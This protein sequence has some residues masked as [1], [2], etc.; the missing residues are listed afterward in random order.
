MAYQDYR[1]TLMPIRGDPLPPRTTVGDRLRGLIPYAPV[2][3]SVVGAI[4]SAREARKNRE[5][6][7]RMSNTAHQR[8]VADLRSAGLNPVLS[9]HGGASSPAGSMGDM[10]G[11]GEAIP[12]GIA[13]AL[14]IRQAEAQIGLTDAQ[15]LQARTQ[16]YDLQTS[17]GSRYGLID[18]QR[19]VAE[20]NAAQ[21]RE[22]LPL[23]V[24][25]ARA[26]IMRTISG[27]RAAQAVAAL[28]EAALSGAMNQA[29][30]E[31]LIGEAGPALRLLFEAL[32]TIRRPR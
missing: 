7:E 20:G 5:F 26:E 18:A 17:A 25:Q 30:F 2:I 15:A 14:G 8:E 32:R 9:G 29:E 4:A 6:Q 16:A 23:M 10:S 24:E 12:K 28:D 22:M 31:K 1:Q 13:A 19:A 11:F 21:V 3:G 27:A